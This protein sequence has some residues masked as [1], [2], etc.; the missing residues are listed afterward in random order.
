MRFTI[1]GWLELVRHLSLVLQH[2]SSMTM[3]LQL[4][5]GFFA[6]SSSLP[7]V[8][9]DQIC[10]R[11]RQYLMYLMIIYTIM[12]NICQL[13]AQKTAWLAMFYMCI[14]TGIAVGYVYG[15]FVSFKF[16]KLTS[17]LYIYKGCWL[18]FQNSVLFLGEGGSIGAC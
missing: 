14:P 4:R 6:F 12:L 18:N 8:L 9:Y 17:Y 5:F 13:W 10:F 15:G 2:H 7:I 1:L 11:G 16:C 3:L